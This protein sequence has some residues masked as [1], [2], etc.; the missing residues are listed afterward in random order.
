MVHFITFLY[1]IRDSST[2]QNHRVSRN[3]MFIK[4]KIKEHELES[5]YL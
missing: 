1:L 5:I 2:H 3:D 4:R